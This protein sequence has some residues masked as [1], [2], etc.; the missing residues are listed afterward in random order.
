[1][2][3]SVVTGLGILA[4]MEKPLCDLGMYSGGYLGKNQSLESENG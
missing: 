2:D 4:F 3:V 1:M